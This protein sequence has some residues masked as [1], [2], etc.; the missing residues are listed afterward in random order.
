MKKKYLGT[1]KI[2][3]MEQWDK[4][5]IDLVVPGHITVD[6]TGQG[7]M[8]FG[9][10]DCDLDF[11]VEHVGDM[12]FLQF[13]FIGEDEGDT[14]VGRGWAILAGDKLQGKIVFHFG[15]ESGFVASKQK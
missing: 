8:Q 14:V 5:Y 11:R 10:V 4:D 13:S 12:E 3:E 2:T 9:V 1:W 6:K 15:D 7:S